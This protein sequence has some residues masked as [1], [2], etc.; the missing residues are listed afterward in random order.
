MDVE[1]SSIALLIIINT[2]ILIVVLVYA[3]FIYTWDKKKQQYGDLIMDENNITL[4]G[5]N[6][7][8]TRGGYM[9]LGE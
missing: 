9:F 2:I 7:F 1:L 4:Q 5:E 6:E 8:G 3:L